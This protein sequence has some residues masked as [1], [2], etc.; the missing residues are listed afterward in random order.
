MSDQQ[1]PRCEECRNSSHHWLFNEDYG[2]TAETLAELDEEERALVSSTTH[3][4]TCK[5]CTAVGMECDECRGEG[6]E[7]EDED[8][9]E[10]DY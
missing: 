6:G 7:D 10:D 8:E 3:T 2:L 1:C 5:H 4:H 9:D